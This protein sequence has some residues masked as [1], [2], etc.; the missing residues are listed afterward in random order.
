MPATVPGQPE[1][2]IGAR[3]VRK[4]LHDQFK[5]NRQKGISS[6]AEK[7]F[8]FVFTGPSGEKYGYDNALGDD[9]TL[10]YY[11]EGRVGD[12]EFRPNNANTKLRDHRERGLDLHV[13]VETLEDGV[14]SYLGEYVC[15]GHEWTD[16]PDGDGD[17][18]RA[19]RF[20]L[21]PA[22]GGSV[23]LGD[24]GIEGASE[25]DLFVAARGGTPTDDSTSPASGGGGTYSR[26][27]LLGRFALRSADGVCQGCGED[28]RFVNTDGDPLLEVH[29]LYRRSD[30]GANSPENV[31]GLC[32][33]C[34][35]RCHRDDDDEE[36]TREL[37]ETAEKRNDRLRDTVGKGTTE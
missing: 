19:I 30:G 22:D 17:T 25:R 31:V 28:V 5:G 1:F 16:A 10:M 9:G 7:D 26:R 13:F 4:E 15:D 34:H 2:E 37:I 3:Y 11:G 29:H 27:E 6:P 32:S 18:R 24:K 14:V 36:F 20:R 35:R 23:S 8:V 33:D 21:I 12:M